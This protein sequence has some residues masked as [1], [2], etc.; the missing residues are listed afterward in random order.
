MFTSDRPPVQSPSEWPSTTLVIAAYNEEDVIEEKIENSLELDYPDDKFD[1]VVFSDA[2]S[3]R[4]DELVK[5]YAD[6]GVELMRIEGRVGK[7]ECQNQVTSRLDSD[8]IVYSD[9]NSMYEPDAIK[10]L[11]ARFSDGVGCVV[12]EL[13][14][15]DDSDVE[16]ESLYWRYEQAI[17]KLEARFHSLVTGNGSIYAVRRS[18]YVPLSPGGISDF[19][20]PLAVVSNGERIDYADDAVAWERTGE[21]VESEMSRRIRI[22]TRCWN[23]VTEFTELLNPLRYPKFAFQFISHKILRWLSPLLLGTAFLANAV[24]LLLDANP[25]YTLSFVVQV[26]F[27]FSAVLGW[28]SERYDVAIP[29]PVH[30]TYYF[31]VSNVGMVLGLWKFLKGQNIVT[32]ETADRTG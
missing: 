19:A 9:A 24:L 4:T 26:L 10:R 3:D 31:I 12:G 23:T 2:S 1:I 6:E 29:G 14:Y 11:I 32:W 21:S 16:G 17:K 8:F 22:V 28:V 18:S 27:Y 7:T 20:E 25:I 5:G 13:R 30:V 15:S